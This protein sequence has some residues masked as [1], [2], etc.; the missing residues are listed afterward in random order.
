MI[1]ASIKNLSNLQKD[2][3]AIRKAEV[4]AL[5]TAVKVEGYRLRTLLKNEIKS[6]SPG[7]RT[8]KPLTIMAR[9]K[10]RGFKANKPLQR[11]AL[12]IRYHV[13]KQS[14]LELHIGWTGPQVSESWKRIAERQ[15]EGFSSP[16]TERRRRFFMHRGAELSPRSSNRKYLFLKDSTHELDTPARPITDPFWQAH[17]VES[18]NNIR[19]N[20]RRKL[21]GERI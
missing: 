15:Q 5:D 19:N 7:G 2:I 8:F 4:K 11:L 16:V 13:A 14:P 12:G 6:G 18:W 20:F 1:E 3:S 10:G 17:R 9:R 21:R